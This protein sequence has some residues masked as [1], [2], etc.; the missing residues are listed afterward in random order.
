MR[1]R[2]RGAQLKFGQGESITGNSKFIRQQTTKQ[3]LSSGNLQSKTIDKQVT[4]LGQTALVL[5]AIKFYSQ[6]EP[7]VNNL[8]KEKCKIS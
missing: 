5:I 8:F 6:K 7:Y 2:L 4:Q 1:S 3:F